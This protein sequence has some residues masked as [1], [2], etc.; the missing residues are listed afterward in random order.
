MSFQNDFEIIV[1]NTIEELNTL[2]SEFKAHF[3]PIKII[4]KGTLI[5][6]I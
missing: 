4:G 6:F 2:N 1:K 3:I 5:E